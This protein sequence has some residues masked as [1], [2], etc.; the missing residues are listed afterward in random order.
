MTIQLDQTSSSSQA[1]RNFCE[2]TIFPQKFGLSPYCREGGKEGKKEGK[3]GK[4][5]K[6]GDSVR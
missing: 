3:E 2:N 5:K 4:E 1:I 6:K